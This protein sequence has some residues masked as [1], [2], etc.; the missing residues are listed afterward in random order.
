MVRRLVSVVSGA[1]SILKGR[2]RALWTVCTQ[3]PDCWDPGLAS[4][5]PGGLV[6]GT[7]AESYLRPL[8]FLSFVFICVHIFHLSGMF[9]FYLL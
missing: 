8:V 7:V 3:N 5:V 9:S 1:I 6:T 2:C 4:R